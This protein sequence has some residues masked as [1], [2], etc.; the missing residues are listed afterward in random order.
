MVCHSPPVATE[1]QLVTGRGV[2]GEGDQW[3]EGL[4]GSRR[5]PAPAGSKR[6]WWR[7]GCTGGWARRTM[8]TGLRI[9]KMADPVVEGLD[10]VV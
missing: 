7:W 1:V 4:V 10:P 6:W 3:E 2:H 9:R 5:I 8:D